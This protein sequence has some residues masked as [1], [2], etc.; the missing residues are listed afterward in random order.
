MKKL[1]FH[2]NYLSCLRVV[3]VQEQ[4]YIEVIVESINKKTDQLANYQPPPH[5]LP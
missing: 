2:K 5:N 1:K 4:L 3:T